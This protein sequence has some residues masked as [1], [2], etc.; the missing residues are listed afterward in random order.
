MRAAS[1]TI[2]SL[3]VFCSSTWSILLDGDDE[4]AIDHDWDYSGAGNPSLNQSEEI[5]VGFQEGNFGPVPF[6]S[7]YRHLCWIVPQSAFVNC[8][9][10]NWYGQLGD[11]G[12][13]KQRSSTF[14]T[15][16]LSSHGNPVSISSGEG[17]TCAITDRG[18]VVCLGFGRFWAELR[19]L[20]FILLR[21]S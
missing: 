13:N 5:I 18:L 16:D 8:S 3:I 19:V 4:L 15:V 12:G 11:G 9:G 6:S 14:G 17:H 10:D 7:G 1:S 20:N 2:L 21:A